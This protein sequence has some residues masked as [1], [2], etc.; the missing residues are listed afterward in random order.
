MNSTG[1]SKDHER[2]K[3]QYPPVT[4]LTCGG[5]RRPVTDLAGAVAAIPRNGFAHVI[6]M[7][8]SQRCIDAFEFNKTAVAG[9]R[10]NGTI[11]EPGDETLADL[12]LENV[13]QAIKYPGE[14]LERTENWIGWRT[15]QPEIAAAARRVADLYA[16]GDE[17][18]NR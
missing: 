15:L 12:V 2:D 18:R 13:R 10:W 16:E 5:C 1:G 9:L 17:D 11:P 3:A 14:N 7:H 8:A 4:E 6:P